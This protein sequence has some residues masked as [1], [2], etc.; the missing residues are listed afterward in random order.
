MFAKAEKEKDEEVERR[1]M[2]MEEVQQ[3]QS[4]QHEAARA[5]A[6]ANYAAAKIVATAAFFKNLAYRQEVREQERRCM[7]D[8]SRS[9]QRK[10]GLPTPD[11][12]REW[13][14]RTYVDIKDSAEEDGVANPE[15]SL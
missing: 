11:Q 4:R 8:R 5:A 9:R 1:R 12:L 13:S 15:Q 3:E 2:E 10:L 14:S 6:A 7:R